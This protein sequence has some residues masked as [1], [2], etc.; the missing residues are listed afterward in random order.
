MEWAV[1]TMKLALKKT[2]DKRKSVESRL[3]QFL[4]QYRITPHTTAGVS[5]AELLMGRQ[6]RSH[7]SL[8]YPG[9]EE[10]VKAT[11][12][13]QSKYHNRGA[14]ER[15]FKVGDHVWALN[16]R[17]GPKWLSG[18]ISGIRGLVSVW[19]ELADGGKVKCHYDQICARVAP[20]LTEEAQTTVTP[21]KSTWSDLLPVVGPVIQTAAVT[22]P[23]P[24]ALRVPVE[25][26]ELRRSGRTRRLPVRF[27]EG[28][29]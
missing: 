17:S 8:L 24:P 1:Q 26:P 9:V 4:F 10:R 23:Q 22:E 21:D 14:K 15:T 11:Q 13:K 28:E 20:I 7:L 3:L 18:V 25:R 16:H 29:N 19:V 5:P 2:A 6:L 12:E 27:K